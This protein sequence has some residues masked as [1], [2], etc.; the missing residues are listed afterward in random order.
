MV[1]RIVMASAPFTL[2][3]LLGEAAAASGFASP[4]AEPAHPLLPHAVAGPRLIDAKAIGKLKTFSG[5]EEDWPA[6]VFVARS[7]VHLLDH[8]R[9][10]RH[11]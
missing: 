10:S 4:A 2:P 11:A 9:L 6:W 3:Q 7:Y 8:A 5:K 1:A